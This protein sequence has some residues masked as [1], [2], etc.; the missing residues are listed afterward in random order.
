MRLYL[1]EMLEKVHLSSF[2]MAAFHDLNK[3][4]TSIYT[5]VDGAL[6]IDKELRN[7]KNG[8]NSLPQ[9]RV[10]QLTTHYQMIIPENIYIQITL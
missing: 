2:N 6:T 9:G 5:N 1:L 10:H 8:R 4:N 7:A 3:D